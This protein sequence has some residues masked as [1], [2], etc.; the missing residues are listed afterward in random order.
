MAWAPVLQDSSTWRVP[1]V[2]EHQ[3]A[4]IV[5]GP[6]AVD[7]RIAIRPGGGEDRR[8]AERGGIAALCHRTVTGAIKSS[9][10]QPKASC[11]A[12][13]SVSQADVCSDAL[14]DW[15]LHSWSYTSAYKSSDRQVYKQ[16][17]EVS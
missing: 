16:R 4:S 5:Q 12:G 14:A 3:A 8:S 2:E 15:S 9:D 7:L 17:M 11:H 10:K 13:R 1:L 6:V